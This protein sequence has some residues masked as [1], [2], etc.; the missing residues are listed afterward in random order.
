LRW[1]QGP[2]RALIA[3]IP[4]KD[5]KFYRAGMARRESKRL[6]NLMAMPDVGAKQSF[7]CHQYRQYDRQVLAKEDVQK[8]DPIRYF[9]VV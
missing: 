7:T 9:A 4:A 3:T 6:Q 2:R 1:S 5:R 8:I